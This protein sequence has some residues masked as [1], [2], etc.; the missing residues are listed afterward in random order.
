MSDGIRIVTAGGTGEVIEKKSRFIAQVMPARSEE[1][2]LAFINS[3][4]KKY[5][6]ARHNCYAF[7]VGDQ[8][9]LTRSSDDGEPSGTAGKPILEVLLKEQIHNCVVVVTRYFGGTL[10]GTGGLIRAYQAATQ[11]GL[12]A[13][14]IAEKH[15]GFLYTLTC[16]YNSIGKIQYQLATDQITALD[17][18][19]TDVVSCDLALTV[20]Q[21]ERLL[22]ALTEI[23]AGKAVIEKKDAIEFLLSDGAV[24]LL[25]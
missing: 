4:K 17:T 10:L 14:E 19:Y 18:R 12:R 24:R 11:E 7:T 22:P 9:E 25:D 6:D 20:Q 15:R 21:S 2:A 23:T 13:S 5:W 8:F 3:V 1:D 16:D